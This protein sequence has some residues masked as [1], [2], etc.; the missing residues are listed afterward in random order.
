MTQ[1]SSKIFIVDDD[2]MARMIIADE[3]S[4]SPYQ[5]YEFSDGESCLAAL[6]QR[7]DLI[8][9]DV[10]MPHMD[11][12]Q[13]CQRIKQTAIGQLVDVIF[14][15]GHDTTEEKLAGYDV[16]GSDY[17]IKPV[18]P[19]EL[20][21]K[22]KLALRHR[23]QHSQAVADQQYAM[24]TALT[25]I[26][27]AGEQGVVLDF[28]RRSFTVSGLAELGALVVEAM[29]QFGVSSCIQL[30][31]KQATVNA[32]SLGE[33]TPLEVELMSRL[34]EAGRIKEVG[35][36]LVANFG[37]ISLLIKN[38][39]D[40]EQ[41]R[42]R[43][44]DHLALLLEGA[45][46]RMRVLELNQRLASLVIDSRETLRQIEQ[47]QHENKQTALQIMD[48]VVRD[49]EALFM[50]LGLSEEQETALL[51]IVQHGV[52][53]SLNNFEQG[54]SLDNTLRELVQQLSELR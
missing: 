10:E 33:V 36:R 29:N 50:K 7:P 35:K 53:R 13:T 20:L 26:S 28:M 34:R 18:N 12:Y 8:L 41:R 1:E 39:P 2:P 49:L 30:R 16:G 17:I 31:G 4:N 40:E 11:G 5:L 14:V 51:T 27:S 21:T 46:S 19:Q 32:A 22:V 23:E 52:D 6:E 15:S 44:R 48:D 54:I 25:A 45:E 43:L 37:D 38:M 3:F 9:L 47:M 24:H 42:G